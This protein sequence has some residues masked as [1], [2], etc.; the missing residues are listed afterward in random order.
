MLTKIMNSVADA[1]HTQ[2][3][4]QKRKYTDEDY[5]SDHNKQGG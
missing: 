3:M 4:G 5:E 2:K 1:W